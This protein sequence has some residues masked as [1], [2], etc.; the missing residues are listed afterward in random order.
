MHRLPE[1]V[2]K[3]EEPEGAHEEFAFG[4]RIGTAIGVQYLRETIF[5]SISFEG[6]YLMAEFVMQDCPSAF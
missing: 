2:Q 1:G 4:E 6:E 3:R 5:V